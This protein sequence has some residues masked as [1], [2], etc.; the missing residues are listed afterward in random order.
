M[1]KENFRNIAIIAHVD[2]GKTTLVDAMLRQSGIFNEHQ[3]IKDRVMDNLDLERERG[4]TIVAKNTAV[5]YHDIKINII[6]TPG[7]ADFGGEVERGLNMVEGVLLL[8]DASE[9]PLPQTRFVLRKALAKKLP[10]ILVINKIDRKDARAAEVLNDVYDL[11]IELGA[12]EKQIDFPVIYTVARVGAAYYKIGDESKNLIPLFDTILKAIPA[13]EADDNSIPQFLVTNL[14]YDFYIGQVALGRMF[15]GKLDAAT[16][17]SLISPVNPPRT[18]RLTSLFTFH[19]LQKKQVEQ[20][21]AGDIVAISGIENI[22]IGDTITSLENPK[23]LPGIQVDEPTVSMIFYVNSSPFAGREGKYLTT[24]HLR[25]RLELEALRNVSIK[26]SDTDR[27]DAFKVSGRGELQLG[28]LIETMRREDYELMVSKPT[29]I[30]KTIDGKLCEPMERVFFDIPQEF[31]GVITEKMSQCKGKMMNMKSNGSGRVSVEYLCATR[32]MIGFR[33][34]F[35]TDTRGLGVMN[36][37]F[38]GYQEWAGNLRRRTS[39]VLVADRMGQSHSYAHLAM[40]DRGELFIQVG[41]DVYEGMIVGECNR[42]RDIDVNITKEKKLTNMRS[43]TSDQTV[44]LKVP[45]ILS[46]DEA[47]EF[48]EDDELVEVTPTAFRMRK[49]ELNQDK[50]AVLAK[51]RE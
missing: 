20:A 5:Y 21:E 10:V 13:P 37:L 35:L 42:D 28:I 24:R 47:I 29:I 40:E 4:I 17:Y 12:N 15:N 31:V 36:T 32:G 51:T 34:Q 3:E 27:A 46:L 23:P 19:G 43:S 45:R 39:G 7:H 49:M 8:V 25:A 50:R 6:D 9:G 2:H 16:P 26:V 14:D 11:F 1:Y 33:S 30:T 48:I 38:E 41:T 18:V 44:V 22:N